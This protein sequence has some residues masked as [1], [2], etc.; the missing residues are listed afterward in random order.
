M[1]ASGT[2]AVRLDCSNCLCTAC[3][4]KCNVLPVVCAVSVAECTVTAIVNVALSCSHHA[5][6]AH[7]QQHKEEKGHVIESGESERQRSSTVAL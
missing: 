2:A 3:A 7:G 4:T 5:L 6:P 1:L